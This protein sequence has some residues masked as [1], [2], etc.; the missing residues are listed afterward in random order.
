MN[1]VSNPFSSCLLNSIKSV[2]VTGRTI[3]TTNRVMTEY[4]TS[5]CAP[6]SAERDDHLE[7]INI[8]TNN[9]VMKSTGLRFFFK[10]FHSKDEHVF[11]ETCSSSSSSWSWMLWFLASHAS[12]RI[13]NATL[14]TKITLSTIWKRNSWEIQLSHQIITEPVSPRDNTAKILSLEHNLEVPCTAG[15]SKQVIEII[16]K[17]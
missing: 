2:N 1:A 8:H 11:I 9:N 13:T 5:F 10:T 17:L 12:R 6:F 15:W 7:S 4:G 16:I 14:T 3:P